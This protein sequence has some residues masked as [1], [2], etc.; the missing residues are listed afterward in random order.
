MPRAYAFQGSRS[1]CNLHGVKYQMLRGQRVVSIV[2]MKTREIRL[3]SNGHVIAMQSQMYDHKWPLSAVG[4]ASL[5]F[6]RMFTL[7][8]KVAY[9]RAIAAMVGD[10]SRSLLVNANGVNKFR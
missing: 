4:T 1:Q 7:P 8:P 5:E 2:A 9:K 3:H 10:K 6:R